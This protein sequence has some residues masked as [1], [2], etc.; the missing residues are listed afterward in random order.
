MSLKKAALQSVGTLADSSVYFA[1][2]QQG[3]QAVAGMGLVLTILWA[4][5]RHLTDMTDAQYTGNQMMFWAPLI[6][7]CR[8][9]LLAVAFL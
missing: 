8:A 2:K 1:R 3:E 6:A 5:H 9:G 4:L 7:H